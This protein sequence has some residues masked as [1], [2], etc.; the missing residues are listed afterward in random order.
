MTKSNTDE[1]QEAR[2]TR[3]VRL[4]NLY[5]HSGDR[6]LVNAK[7]RVALQTG[8]SYESLGHWISGRRQIGFIADSVVSEELDL[9]DAVRLNG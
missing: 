5:R 8:L 1:V 9:Q 2:R 3:L 6:G 7:L 4:L